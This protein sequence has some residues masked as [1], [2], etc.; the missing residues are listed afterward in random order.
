[1]TCKS[2]RFSCGE[3]SRRNCSNLHFHGDGVFLAKVD[4]CHIVRELPNESHKVRI[5]IDFRVV[6]V[7]KSRKSHIVLPVAKLPWRKTIAPNG[8]VRNVSRL[9]PREELEGGKGARELETRSYHQCGGPQARILALA[10][11][12]NSARSTNP[13]TRPHQGTRRWASTSPMINEASPPV[14][15][16]GEVAFSRYCEDDARRKSAAARRAGRTS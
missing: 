14:P 7:R 1:M 6:R 16:C 3:Q 5:D 9:A 15:A 13:A 11:D 12:K 10:R 4:C 2:S 8:P